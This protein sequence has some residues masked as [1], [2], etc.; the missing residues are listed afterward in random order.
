MMS[1]NGGEVVAMFPL[2]QECENQKAQ[3]SSPLFQEGISTN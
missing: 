3:A 2:E 1:Y